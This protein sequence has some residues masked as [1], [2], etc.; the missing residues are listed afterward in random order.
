[1]KINNIETDYIKLQ[2]DERLGEVSSLSG[3]IARSVELNDSVQLNDF[4][5]FIVW[6]REHKSGL[7]DFI[8]YQDAY[9]LRGVVSPLDHYYNVSLENILK[10][11][12][13]VTMN[14]LS[15][16]PHTSQIKISW[17]LR[18]AD[19]GS[20]DAI[21]VGYVKDNLLRER[22]NLTESVD[23]D[24]NDQRIA[25]SKYTEK[26]G[27]G[28]IRGIGWSKIISFHLES[29][30]T[31]LPMYFYAADPFNMSI[32]LYDGTSGSTICTLSDYK[33]YAALQESTGYYGNGLLYGT[34]LNYQLNIESDYL[35]KA[36]FFVDGANVLEMLE[37][38]CSNPIGFGSGVD[39]VFYPF[40]ANFIL[41]GNT[42]IIKQSDTKV[43][44]T[45]REGQEILDFEIEY[46]MRDLTNKVSFITEG[47]V[48]TNESTGSIDKYGLY[49]SIE[50]V[51]L[52]RPQSW[53]LEN[54]EFYQFTRPE[55]KITISCNKHLNP[56]NKI[57]LKS[58]NIDK[59]MTVQ[60]VLS[61]YNDNEPYKYEATL[62]EYVPRKEWYGNLQRRKEMQ[63]L[64]D[65][66]LKARRKI[67]QRH[68]NTDLYSV[69]MGSRRLCGSK[70][71]F[72]FTSIGSIWD[73]IHSV[74][75]HDSCQHIFNKG[76]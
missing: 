13:D 20:G 42:L 74:D 48:K 27:G 54:K 15:F 47:E 75:I 44:E 51:G 5:G 61:T 45:L 40:Q 9:K 35:N 33:T 26:A 70:L 63:S 58:I 37:G 12:T 34:G 64:W 19:D 67:W 3:T 66:F 7:V 46:D 30:K 32:R 6:Y 39:R 65:I 71:P 18:F 73:H 8:A 41:D 69:I 11:H 23:S 56:G 59:P 14:D 24:G 68:K 52:P 10:G 25:Y 36:R 16:D 17:N 49:E 31:S 76:Q 53:Y 55:E 43:R 2:L 50:E 72:H 62:C 60:S 1:M 21:L 4:K 57:D 29:N 38:I 22:I 28:E